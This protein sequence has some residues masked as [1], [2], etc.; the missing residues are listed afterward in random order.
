[1]V[2]SVPPPQ[3]TQDTGRE[4]FEAAW[5]KWTPGAPPPR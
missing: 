4:A 3:T 5:K 1:M 2:P